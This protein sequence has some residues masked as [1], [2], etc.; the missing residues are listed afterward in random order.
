M[1]DADRSVQWIR[2][3]LPTPMKIVLGYG[4]PVML[5]AA[6]SAVFQTKQ[7]DVAVLMASLGGGLALLIYTNHSGYRVAWDDE[8]VYMRNWGFRNLLFQRYPYHSM[9]FEEMGDMKGYA[10]PELRPT[11]YA[12]N[13]VPELRACL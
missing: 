7:Y 9:T 5:I 3:K 11:R 10:P 1:S 8:R 2:H 4:I 13:A 12:V 6:W